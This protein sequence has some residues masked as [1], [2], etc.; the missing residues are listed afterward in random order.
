MK[1]IL[2]IVAVLFFISAG[3]SYAGDFALLA[4]KVDQAR[5][6][7]VNM[8]ADV[9]PK[10]KKYLKLLTEA[11]DAV[12]AKIASVKAPVGKEGRF[13][14]FIATWKLFVESLDTE[15]IPALMHDDKERA[16]ILVWGVQKERYIKCK[17]LLRE[18]EDDNISSK[19]F[20]AGF[21]DLGLK[22]SEA[23]LSLVDMVKYPSRRD[24]HYL[25]LVRDTA[26]AV[27]TKLADLRA[28]AGKEAEFKELVDTWNAFKETRDKELVPLLLKNDEDTAK[29]LAYGIQHERFSRMLA[30]NKELIQYNVGLSSSMEGGVEEF[31]AK[32]LDARD[33]L[34][35]M[36]R[37]PDKRDAAQQKLV[38]DTADDVSEHVQKMRAPLGKEAILDQLVENWNAFKETREKELVP[39]ILSGKDA[40][41]KKIAYGIQNKRLM[42]CLA[43]AARL[44]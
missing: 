15:L 5:N 32:L 40:E 22:L 31:R 10:D 42:N 33:V 44:N 41:A 26:D 9:N 18:L 13:N 2:C 16:K 43:L 8:M 35:V 25:K 24:E 20:G 34:L 11:I 1:R 39:L 38:K 4:D 21:Q 36:L 30:L 19:G 17:A 27:S 23:R 37:N 28:P 29:K 6:V 14:D 12:N 7:M 3:A